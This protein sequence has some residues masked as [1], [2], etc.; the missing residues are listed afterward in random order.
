[1]TDGEQPRDF[2][3]IFDHF[4]RLDAPEGEQLQ[5]LIAYALYKRAKREWAGERSQKPTDEELTAYVATWTKS[6]RA[7]LSKQAEQL[8]DNYASAYVE[9]AEPYI[10]ARAL[11][12]TFWNAVW[13]GITAAAMYTC[14]LILAAVILH[15][16]G[17]DL[18]ELFRKVGAEPR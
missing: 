17:V 3:P 11:K 5:G 9:A 10:I 4:V 8:L 15:Y 6:Q 12:G 7:A 14:L 13:P 16:T 18:L 1:M 2:N